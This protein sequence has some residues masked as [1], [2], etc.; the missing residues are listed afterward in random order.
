MADVPLATQHLLRYLKHRQDEGVKRAFLTDE[1]KTG[2]RA[3]YFHARQPRETVVPAPAP[4]HQQPVQEEKAT[5]TKEPVPQEQPA[6]TDDGVTYPK[7]TVAEV[8]TSITPS[9]VGKAAQLADLKARI[10]ED[11]EARTVDLRDTMVFSTGSLDP[12]IMFIGEAPGSEEERQQEPFVGPAG[13]LLT[14]IIQAMGLQR[15]MVYISNIVKYR[16]GMP[17]QGT[18][19]R[20]PTNDEMHA[21]LPYIMAETA[22]VRPKVIVALGGTALEGLTGE[23]MPIGRARDQVRCWNGIPFVVTYH[24]SYLLRND[25]IAE[26]RKVWEDMMLVMEVLQMPISDKQ[27]GFFSKKR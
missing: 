26:K 25:D 9:G 1:A 5:T 21:C 11:N 17:N 4:Q 2:L 15:E 19:N 12:E 8:R 23:K 7:I 6:A 13:K 14:K 27:R 18:R 20:K 10:A 3:V 24:P 16:P 22:I